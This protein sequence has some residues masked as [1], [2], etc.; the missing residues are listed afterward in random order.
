MPLPS[1][2]ELIQLGNDLI[3]QIDTLF[4]LHPGFRAVH[5]KGVLLKGAFHPSAEAA[6]LTRA[7]HTTRDECVGVHH[8]AVI[9]GCVFEASQ[10]RAEVTESSSKLSS[11]PPNRIAT[12]S[13]PE[14]RALTLPER[15]AL[16]RA[17]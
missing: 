6:S 14:F 4:G 10:R 15:I 12:Y 9:S 16:S 1:D 13:V 3:K 7:P 8:G 11:T 5:S 2:E 17:A